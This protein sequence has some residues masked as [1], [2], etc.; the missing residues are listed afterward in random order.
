MQAA[1]KQKQDNSETDTQQFLIIMIDAQKFGIPIMQIQDVL[2]NQ[3]IAHIPLAPPEVAG[4][5]N[6]RGRIVTAIDVKKRL[7]ICQGDDTQGN[8]SVVIEHD[9]ELYSLIIDGVGD[10]LRLKKDSYEA[11]PATLDPLWREIALGIH[12]LESELLVILDI[13]RLLDTVHN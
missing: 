10:V 9:N 4:A 1:E 6:L 8:V 13:P 3:K 12:R 7:G 11:T 2:K 5:L